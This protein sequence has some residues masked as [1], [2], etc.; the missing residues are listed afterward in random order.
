MCLF[1]NL[2][3]VTISCIGQE[4]E[5]CYKD[6]FI[7]GRKFIKIQQSDHYEQKK[8]KKK[9]WMTSLLREPATAFSWG[10]LIILTEALAL[11]QEDAAAEEPAELLVVVEI[12]R[13]T[14]DS[15]SSAHN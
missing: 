12:F 6:L 9:N 13:K 15:R 8:K 14:G 3:R 11:D 1:F 5:N 4:A 2:Q 7:R 10:P